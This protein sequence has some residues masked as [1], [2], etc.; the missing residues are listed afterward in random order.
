LQNWGIG[1]CGVTDLMIARAWLVNPQQC[2]IPRMYRF[3]CIRAIA[4][5]VAEV[6][7]IQ[8]VL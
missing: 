3:K 7:R 2:N 5:S 1:W 4:T 8:K 6:N